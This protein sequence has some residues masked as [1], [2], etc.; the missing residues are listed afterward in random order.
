MKRI[1]FT[2]FGVFFVFAIC[3]TLLE[4]LAYRA[5]NNTPAPKGEAMPYDRELLWRLETGKND[6]GTITAEISEEGFREVPYPS[7]AKG[8]ILF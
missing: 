4:I 5:L 2:L 3:W 7:D 6:F 8:D 1:V